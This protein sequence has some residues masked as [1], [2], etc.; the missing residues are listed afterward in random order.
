MA[1]ANSVP[2]PA[3]PG[4]QRAGIAQQ[5]TDWAVIDLARRSAVWAGHARRV[6]AFF[7]K[8]GFVEDQHAVG[9]PQM[10]HAIDAQ[11][12][13]DG[14]GVPIGAA[15]PVLEAIGRRL[16]ADFRH[17]PAVLALGR[18][19]QAAQTGQDP[20]AGLRAG[21]IGG[22][23]ARH[24]GQGGSPACN[25]AGHRSRRGQRC[26]RRGVIDR[27]HGSVLYLCVRNQDSTFKILL[28]L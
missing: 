3:A 20:L 24:I 7:E 16:A 5:D 15:Q 2:D 8:P 19:E 26:T 1:E 17:L 12:V 4:P 27:S 23:P 22:Q 28:P 6:R 11:L 9:I 21:E 14:V 13:A 10:L 25:G 18:T